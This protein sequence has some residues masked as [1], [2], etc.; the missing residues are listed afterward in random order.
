MGSGWM[1]GWMGGWVGWVDGLDWLW[2]DRWDGG[3]MVGW[4]GGWL[5]RRHGGWHWMDGWMDGWMVLRWLVA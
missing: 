1:D 5:D 4:M 3:M 2:T